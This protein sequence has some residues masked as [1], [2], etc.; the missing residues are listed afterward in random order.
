[1]KNSF[2]NSF[3]HIQ[4]G[5]ISRNIQK[6]KERVKGRKVL[7]VVKCDAYRHGAVQVSKQIENV[8][9]W[10]AVATVDEGIELRMGGIKKPILVFG[11][12]AYDNA[13]AYITHNLTATISHVSHFSILMDGTSYHLNFDTGMGRLGFSPSQRREVRELAVVNQ[14]LLCRGIYSHYA[15]A[16]DPGSAF[17]GEQQSRFKAVIS[18]FSEIPLV[19]MSNTGASTNYPEFDHFHMIRTGLGMLGYNSGHTRHNWL[20]PALTWKSTAV[21]VR[22]I[23]KGNVVSYSSTWSCPEDGYLATIP[24]GYGDGVPR[25]LSNK[26]K[27]LI[28]DKLY[29]Q[30]GNVTMDYFMVYLGADKIPVGSEVTLLGDKAWN[31]YDWAEKGGTNVHEILTNI[32]PRVAKKYTQE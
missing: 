26:L 14:R 21:Q 15:T 22:P 9:D 10:L 25:S 20:E 31:A 3:V 8:V 24:V 18:D 30:V 13:A 12:P 28:G 32:T 16:D 7:A 23:E 2:P 4:L 17:A 29:P 6:I 11:V 5:S 1:M 19:H 27:V